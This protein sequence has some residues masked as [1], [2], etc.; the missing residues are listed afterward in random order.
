MLEF[1]LDNMPDTPLLTEALAI[2]LTHSRWA[3]LKRHA[4]KR[5]LE[6]AR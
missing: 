3:L 4:V 2:N 6:H 5:A 1:A